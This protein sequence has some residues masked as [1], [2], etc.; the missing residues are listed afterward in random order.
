MAAATPAFSDSARPRIGMIT[1]L[2]ER[3]SAES[4]TPRPSL[5]M[6]TAARES[7]TA[8]SGTLSSW[9]AVA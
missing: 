5:P 1:R 8:E 9:S 6:M 3:H 4:L 7:D 2:S